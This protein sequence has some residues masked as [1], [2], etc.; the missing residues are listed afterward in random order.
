MPPRTGLAAAAL[1]VASF[2]FGATFVVIKDAVSDFPPL[3]FVGW[4]FLIGSVALL[5]LAFPRNTRQ[6]RD[7]LIAGSFLFAG[8]AL[9]TAG[10]TLTGASNSALITGLYVVF[11]PLLT[12]A[13]RK[14]LPAAWVWVGAVLAFVGLVLLTL[15][16]GVAFSAGDLLTVGCALA[17]AGHIAALARLAPRHPVVPFTAAQLVVVT[18]AA[19]AF[20]LLIEGAPVPGS[21]QVPALALTGL[22]VSAGAFLLQVWAQTQIGPARTAVILALEPAF[23]VA[24]AAVVLG[25]RLPLRGWVGA[26]IILAAIYLVVTT[27]RQTDT[28]EAEAITAAH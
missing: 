5:L 9:Q 4:R 1:A 11:T 22:G 7:G 6:W 18:V 25:E 23:G 12:A 26:G 10:L 16:E 19:F 13:L 14:R 17:F 28:L 24:T 15:E 8:Y 2:L 3:A 21:E 20:S 27:T